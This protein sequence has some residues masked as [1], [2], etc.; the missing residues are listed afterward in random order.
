LLGYSNFSINGNR[1]IPGLSSELS[2]STSASGLNAALEASYLVPLSSTTAAT[3]VLAKPL[4]G[5]AWGGYGQ[6]GFSESG[7]SFAQ[8]V[9]SRTA[10]SL[11]GTVGVELMTNPLPLNASRTVSIT[12]RLALAYQGDFLA[13]NVQNK[14]VDSSFVGAPSAGTLTTEGQNLGP[15]NL[16]LSG[17]FSVQVTE[18]VDVYASATYLLLS[19]ANQFSYGGGLR[20]KF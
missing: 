8:S 10:N 4:L 9:N 3:Q 13:N 11:L 6:S 14:T 15:N 16:N 1:S 19:N 7:G 17:G 18:N 20:M 5:L 2:G 12:P